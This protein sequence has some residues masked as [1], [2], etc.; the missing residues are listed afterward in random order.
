MTT[1]ERP[2]PDGGL[3]WR[4]EGV[5][6][7]PAVGGAGRAGRPGLAF[8]HSAGHGLPLLRPGTTSGLSLQRPLL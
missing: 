8:A 2:H 3:A 5:A 4:D 6:G 7:N 1:D